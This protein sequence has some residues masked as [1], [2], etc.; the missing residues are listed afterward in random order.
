MRLLMSH[1]AQFSSLSK[2]GELLCTQGLA[3]LLQNSDARKSFGDHISKMVGRTINADLTWRAEARQKDG[4]RPDLEGCTADGKLVVKIE[5]KLGAAFGEGQL[6]SYLDDLQE[7]SDSG[8]LLVLVPHYRVAAMKASVPCVSAPTEDGPWQRGATSDFSVA[9][10]DWEGVLVALKDVRSEPFRGDLAQFRA[11]YRVLQGYDIEPL[12]SVSELFAWRERKEVFVNLVDR[13]TRRLAQQSRVL[14]MGK[15]GPDDYQ[16][17]YV[18]LPLGADEPCFSVGVRDPFPGYTTPIWLRFHRLTPKFSVIRERLVA[19][20]FAQRLTECG[21]HIWI[22]LDVPL[23]A[24][25]ES[26]VDSLVE[27]AQRVIEVAYQPL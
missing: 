7:S 23:N 17:R 9:V 2:Q 4:A 24:D 6:S 26:L 27:Q 19:S 1:L 10:I 22:H 25:G 5:A 21:G 15:D 16:R 12:R 11:M 18:C 20:G 8:M 3:Y 13:V 14:P